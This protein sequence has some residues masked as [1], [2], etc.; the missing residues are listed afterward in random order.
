MIPARRLYVLAAGFAVA[1]LACLLVAYLRR[2]NFEDAFSSFI[3]GAYFDRAE[4]APSFAGEFTDSLF[5]PFRPLHAYLWLGL[6]VG[7]AAA[8]VLT[9][10]VGRFA[11]VASEE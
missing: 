4:G 10:A 9:L 11:S 7:L 1:A 5:S 8:A 6:G 2:N 3:A